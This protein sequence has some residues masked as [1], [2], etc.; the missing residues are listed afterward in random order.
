[1]A[2][3]YSSEV[4]SKRGNHLFL[5][6]GLPHKGDPPVLTVENYMKWY[7]FWLVHYNGRIEPLDFGE[8]QQM[9]HEM[10]VSPYC[11]HV[12]NP[13]VVV[14]WAKKMNFHL[15]PGALEAIIGRWELEY[16]ERYAE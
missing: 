7:E 1:M 8:L 15:D 6:D 12:P 11:D 5:H 2:P 14:A 4:R 13:D 3:P 10:R 16:K 9:A